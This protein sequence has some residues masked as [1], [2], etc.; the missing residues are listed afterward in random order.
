VSLF[1]DRAI[2]YR[3]DN[4]FDDMQ[5]RLSVGVQ[6]M[7]RSDRGSADWDFGPGFCAERGTRYS[8][9]LLSRRGQA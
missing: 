4:K 7:I 8:S 3:I 6:I 5:V 2:K 9:A 1:N